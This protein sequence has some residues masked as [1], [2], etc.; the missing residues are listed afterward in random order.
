MFTQ[1]SVLAL[2]ICAALLLPTP[3]VS[4]LSVGAAQNEVRRTRPR[5]AQPEGVLP[6]VEDVKSE[7]QLEREAPSAIPSTIPS[8]RNSG[9]PW[10]G[11]RVRDPSPRDLARVNR[12]RQR[13]H[14]S[15][16]TTS[17]PPVYDNQFVDNFFDLT[18]VRDPA[19]TETTYWHDQLRIAH[20]QGPGSLKLAAMEL[21]RT[22]FESAE[23]FIRDRNAHWYVYDLYKTYLMREP[24]AGGWAT[25]EA[26]VPTH[27]RE[28]VRRGFEESGEFA[29]LTANIVPNGTV[30]TS[31][32]SLIS[33]RVDPRN[34]PGHGMLTRDANWSVPL[35]SLPGRNGLDLGLVLSYSSM[36]W[37]RSGPYIYFDEDNGFP[38]PG[39]RLGFPTVQRKSFNSQTKKNAYLLITPAGPRIELRQS[40]SNIYD[41]ADSSY[42]RLTEDG[43]TLLVHSTDGTRLK[44]TEFN[45]EYRCIEVKDRNGNFI[46]INYNTLGRITNITD[47]LGRVIVFNY[48]SNA[49]LLSITQSW[50]AQPAHQWVSFGWGTRTMQSSFSGAAVVGIKNGTV[51]PVITQVALNDTSHFTFDYTNSLQL[52]VVKNYFGTLERNATT[53]AYE[54]PANDA[55]RLLSSS[56][57]ARNWTGYNNVPAQV[58]TQYSVDANGAC[59]LTAPDGTVYKEYYGSGWQRGLTIRSEVLLGGNL[60]KWTTTTWTQDTLAAAYEVNPRVVETNVHD[61]SQNRRRRVIDYGSYA[62]YGLPHVITEFAANSVDAIRQTSMDYNLGSVYLQQHIIGLVSQVQVTD[63]NGQPQSK[64]TYAHDDPGRLQSV[65]AAATQHDAAYSLTLTA[66]GNVTAVSRWDVTDVNNGAKKLTS[67]INYYTTGTPIS[68]TDPAGHQSTIAYADSFSDGVPRNTFAYPTTLTDADSFNSYVQYNFDFGATTRTQSPAPA[69]QSQGTIQTMTYNS[70]AQL[71]RIT[72]TNN[73]AYKRFW[74]G[75]EYTASYATVNNVA[76]E[77]YS[78]Q[79]TDGL[80]RVIGTLGN[81]PGSLGGYRLVNTVYELMGRAWLQ[82]NPTEVNSSWV[83][84]GDDATGIYYTQQTY[85]WRGRPLVI[86]NPDGT[87]KTASYAGCG[88]AGGEVVTLTDEGTI[89][90]GMAK[91]RQQKIYSD[92]L[93]RTVKTEILS[94]ENGS[95]YSATVYTYNARDQVTFIRRFAG[96]APANPSDLSCPSGTCQKTEMTYDGYGRL[97]TK[98]TPAQQV[99]PNNPASTD[100]STWEY[101]GDDTIQQVTDPRGTVSTYTHNNRHLVTGV[102]YS[103]LS[104]VPTTGPSGVALSAPLTFSYDAAGNRKTMADGMGDVDYNYDQLSR[105]TS[106]TRHFTNLSGSSTGGDYTLTYT[107]NVRNELTSVTDPYGAQVNYNFDAAGRISSVTGTPFSA[108]TFVSNIQY[109]AWGAPKSVLHGNGRTAAS[110][111]DAR[112]RISSYELTI[113]PQDSLKL[114]NHY[115]YYADGRLKKMT[116]QDDHEP[117]IIGAP[118]TARHFSRIYDFDRAGR[119]TRAKGIKPSGVEEDRPFTQSYAYDGFDNLT[120]RSGKYYYQQP[121]TND[122][123]S[124]TNNRRLGTDYAA[125]GQEIRSTSNGMVRDLTYDA[126]GEMVQVKETV[127]GTS[128]VSTYVTSYDGDGR[129]LREFLQENA[130]NTNTYMVRS[131]ILGGRVITRLNNAGNKVST[132][133]NID[134][135]VTPVRIGAGNTG[136]VGWTHIDPMG[137]SEGGDT[138]AV[139]DP[140]GNRVAWQP[141]PTGPPPLTYPR[142]SASF[143][144][145]GSSF[146]SAQDRGCV[147]NDR[148]VSCQE[149]NHQIWLG[150]VNVVGRIGV[151]PVE[152]PYLPLG[153]AVGV[154]VQDD[155][156]K[157]PGAQDDEENNIVRINKDED[158]RGHYE[159]YFMPQKRGFDIP[160][161]TKQVNK[162]LSKQA[163]IDFANRILNAVSTKDN[164]V[165][166][167]G[168]LQ[169][170]FKNF[171]D[172]KNGGYTRNKPRNSGGFGSPTGLIHKG[173]GKIFSRAFTW[174]SD[175]QQTAYDVGTTVAELFHMAGRDEYYTDRA[176]AEA[177][178]NIPEYAKMSGFLSPTVFDPG[179]EDKKGAAE[180][181]NHGG[182]SS[183]FHDIQKRLC[184]P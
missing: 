116:D 58:T 20:A 156:D 67:Y 52:S 118:D 97:K 5:H 125:D 132:V 15:R 127:T 171:L 96:A 71:E 47:T 113:V 91:R 175:T 138:K 177:V 123:A 78:I 79:V 1:R 56:I 75:A 137:L 87:T 7:S 6:N 157:L 26:L 55:P 24:D 9:K 153:I 44:L 85:D 150:V 51:L 180:D 149:L 106:E 148:P 38:S 43:A 103:P 27:G 178:R 39:F 108:S 100:H 102:S 42:L 141:V 83:A 23:Y 182:W 35:L 49:N 152:A 30:P 41:A 164:P 14:A 48:D 76:D 46:T 120:Q 18:V 69:G 98:H 82:S 53:F 62:Q 10:D 17:P 63:G 68:T 160:E 122:S 131:T 2:T 95:P 8:R 124:F 45:G 90:A 130:T 115:E 147:L 184:G 181:P 28:Y 36:V 126:A 183:Y 144:S 50:N 105:L 84:S 29:T 134:S 101:N 142:T 140:L 31:A 154:W 112:M 129:Q 94:W 4:W 145:L 109:R 133:I 70:L 135:R 61:N 13:A 151:H 104:G 99:D 179:Y 57:S 155:G 34:Q 3:S 19:S 172:Q 88:C 86:T 146:G 143:G 89:D 54:T 161:I 173:N 92:V 111:Y 119:L 165:L 32:V 128:Q 22:L 167:E 174:M 40:A 33:A 37:T 162:I 176:L 74:Y 60:Q 66:R 72:T 121:A 158:G 12:I 136:G 169:E 117:T 11:R 139:Y 93:G 64:T 163:C 114:R 73:G 21:G 159:L 59:V 80:G 107:Y 168:N 166:R 81:H 77:L 16:R 110:T 170:I 25:W 65:P